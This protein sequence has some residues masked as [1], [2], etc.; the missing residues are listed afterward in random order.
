MA[1]MGARLQRGCNAI[2]KQQSP[3]RYAMDTSEDRT[4]GGDGRALTDALAAHGV[5]RRFP[6][7]AVIITEGDTSDSLYVI[8]TGRVKVYLADE[9]GREVVLNVHG[10]GE[11]IG[12]MSLTEGTRTASVI[13]LETCE[14]SIVSQSAFR[15]F[16]AQNPD[17]TYHLIRKL[18][19]RLKVASNGV[20]NLALLDVYGRVARLLIDLAVDRDGSM[21]VPEP[22]TQQEIGNRVGCAREMVSRIFSDLTAGGY[23]RFEGRHI[24]ILRTLPKDW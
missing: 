14:L 18:I 12:E 8:I 13:A 23:I 6:R 17:A 9:T 2:E 4:S 1:T 22:L 11:Y 5:V 24:H 19:H 10:P 7:N 21:V 20:R 3:D 16:I 15:Q